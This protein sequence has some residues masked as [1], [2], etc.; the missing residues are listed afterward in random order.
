MGG[1]DQTRN[2][3]MAAVLSMMVVFGWYALFPPAPPPEQAPAT[4]EGAPGT[5]APEGGAATATAPAA[6]VSRAEA[7]TGKRIPVE[8]P[9]VSGSIR[10]EGGRLDD[11]HLTK[12]KVSQKPGSDTVILLNPAN[13][14]DPY[15]IDH[16]WQ[17]TEGAAEIPLPKA[18]TPWTI[19]SGE[20]LTPETPITLVWDNGAGLI[21]RRKIAVDDQYMF[22]KE[23]S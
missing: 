15:Y 10:L 12:Y 21:F 2:L 14:S 4:A 13:T 20:K 6:P 11:L 23:F 5:P 1:D 7:I 19:E 22:S 9:S 3:I 18:D 16:G 17:R 8:T